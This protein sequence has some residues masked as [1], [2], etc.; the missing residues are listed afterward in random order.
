MESFRAEFYDGQSS[1]KNNVNVSIDELNN[2]LII[3]YDTPNERVIAPTKIK[4]SVFI[5]I[6]LGL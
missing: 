5:K 3:G 6:Q 2:K 1:R 4:A